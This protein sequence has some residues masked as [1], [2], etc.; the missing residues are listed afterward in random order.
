MAIK[1]KKACVFAALMAV[2]GILMN[3]KARNIGMNDTRFANATGL[4]IGVTVV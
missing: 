3:E 4:R 2:C 1:L